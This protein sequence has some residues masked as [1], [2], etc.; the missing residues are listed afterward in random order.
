MEGTEGVIVMPCKTAEETTTSV[1][2]PMIVP[3]EALNV[4]VPAERPEAKPLEL[5]AAAA[6]LDDA[7]VTTLVMFDVTP[8]VKVPTAVN[9]CCDPLLI[10]TLPGVMTIADSPARVPAPESD[11]D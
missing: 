7:Q 3:E 5:T 10:E 8:P 6:V 4:V 11:T 2:E 9:C 1:A